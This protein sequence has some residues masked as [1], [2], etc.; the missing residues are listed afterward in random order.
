[1][2]ANITDNDDNTRVADGN[3]RVE[4]TGRSGG[5]HAHPSAEHTLALAGTYIERHRVRLCRQREPAGE[6][7]VHQPQLDHARAKGGIHVLKV[8]LRELPTATAG[9]PR[10]T[11][12]NKQ[13]VTHNVKN[14][15]S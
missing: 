6:L 4:E 2:R 13:P 7:A 15:A 8:Q 3:G 9:P 12:R 10:H 14:T 11:T 1:M 5:A